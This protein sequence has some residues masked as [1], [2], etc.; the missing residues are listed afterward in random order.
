MDKSIC[1][2]CLFYNPVIKCSENSVLDASI[3]HCK[4]ILN[5]TKYN[6]EYVFKIV[7]AVNNKCDLYRPA[8]RKDK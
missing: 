1:K 3:G 2:N 8:F 5:A 7:D 6:G 4:N